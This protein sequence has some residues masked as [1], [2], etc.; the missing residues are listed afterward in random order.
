MTKSNRKKWVVPLFGSLTILLGVAAVGYGLFAI[1]QYQL[2]QMGAQEAPPE[3]PNFVEMTTAHSVSFRASSTAIGT[4]IAPRSILLSNEVPGT[5]VLA[6]LTPGAVVEPGTVLLQLDI[7]IEQAQLDGAQA[8]ASIARS[9]FERTREAFQSRALTELELE[10]AQTQ[11]LQAEARVAELRAVIAKKTLLAPFKARIGLSDTHQGQYLPSGTQITSL[12]SVENYL[13]VDFTIPQS[14]AP[15]LQP[16]QSVNLIAQELHLT[17]TILALDSRTDKMTRNVMVRAKIA[18]APNYLQPGDS[19]RVQIEYGDEIQ[20]VAIPAEALRR[21]PEGALAFI[22]EDD[23]KG[24]LRAKQRMVQVIK[25]IGNDVA[26]MSG[27]KSGERVVTI[28]SF[29]LMPGSLLAESIKEP[30]SV[31][32]I[33]QKK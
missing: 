27:V 24:Q 12:Q 14:V 29:K 21:T 2:A 4:I 22:A 30:A 33:S 9:R 5:V 11:V 8:A 15:S 25:S 17:A 31:E 7:S 28:G 32:P 26:L 6:N 1:K 3:A 20:A 16:G 18:D 23:G 13:F 10:E 19:V